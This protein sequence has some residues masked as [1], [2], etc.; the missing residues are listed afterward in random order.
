MCALLSLIS[1]KISKVV[2][3][4]LF[5]SPSLVLFL[6]VVCFDYCV[7]EQRFSSDVWGSL[8]DLYLRAGI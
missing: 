4:V 3:H 7:S 5:L 1:L 2:L 8:V 6:Q